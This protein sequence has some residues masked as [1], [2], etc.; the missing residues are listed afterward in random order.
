MAQTRKPKLIKRQV[1]IDVF[2]QY[3]SDVVEGNVIAG[4]HVI[5]ACQR[6][7]DDIERSKRGEL[8]YIFDKD[9]ASKW[10][11]AFPAL[12]RHTIGDY[13]GS[14]F[15]LSPWQAFIIGSIGGWKDDTGKRRFRRAY[16]SIGRK[17]GKSTLAAGLA[18]LLA[19]FDGEAQSQVYIGATKADQAKII[20]HEAGRMI[21]KSPVLGKISDIRVSQINFP[22][23]DSFIRPLGSD[24]AFD[25]LNPH[26]MIF[27][28]LHAWKELHRPFYD[29]LTTGSAARSQ[30]VRF[31]ITTAGDNKSLIWKEENDYAIN[32]ANGTIKEETYFVYIACL[33]SEEELFDESAWVKS[34]PNIGVSVSVDYV[35]EQAREASVSPI[36]KNRFARYF[37]NIE[38]S[39][40]E[41]AIDPALWDACVKPLSDW[42]H[43]DAV[44]VGLDAGGHNDLGSWCAIARFVD[45]V[46]DNGESDYRYELK[47]FCY[48]DEDTSRDLNEQP[49]Y[50]WVY[51][52][53]IKVTGGLFAAMRDEIMQFMHQHNA[54]EIVFDPWNMRQMGE[55]FISNGFDAMAMNQNR[56]NMHEPL[57]LLLDLIRRKRITH[58][59]S[60]PIYRWALSNLIINTDA[61]GKWMPD[62]KQ[63]S[64]KIDPVVASIMAL[65]RASLAKSRPKGSLFIT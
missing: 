45:G 52:D 37:G 12:F 41:R 31:T 16:T 50:S 18:I 62:R 29:T 7:L 15:V 26:G 51:T 39:S 60:Q 34:M 40:L 57:N 38:V 3:L 14:P 10:I 54:K 11:A 56:F 53:K 1:A 42:R 61:S 24:R 13:A 59:G 6:H 63:S 43:A 44:A 25:G 23:S 47:S 17:N 65:R 33:D 36:A 20:F 49:W 4:K 64:E 32:V 30:P 9:R 35:R 28:E 48:M 19:D 46:R 55:E 21:R 2:E 58:D 22:R 8:P 5:A 27:D